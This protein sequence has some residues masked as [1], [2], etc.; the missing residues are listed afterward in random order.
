MDGMP[1]RTSHT[2]ISPHPKTE[3]IY[4]SLLIMAPS[5]LLVRNNRWRVVL[6]KKIPPFINPKC[7]M[8]CIYNSCVTHD[9]AEVSAGFTPRK[10]ISTGLLQALGFSLSCSLDI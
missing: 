1:G 5:Y 4:S 3:N 9:G 8:R 10:T 7:P 2:T 6:D